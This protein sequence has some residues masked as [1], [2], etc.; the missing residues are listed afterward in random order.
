MKQR[1]L[2]S[3][4]ARV[5][6]ALAAAPMGLAPLA[7]WGSDQPLPRPASPQA[8]GSPKI[9][10]EERHHDWGTVYPGD[11]ITHEFRVFNDGDAPLLIERI[12][13]G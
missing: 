8:E 11:T 12:K 10:F 5:L 9:R 13:P 3:G 6:I 7:S 1:T 2:I 4:A